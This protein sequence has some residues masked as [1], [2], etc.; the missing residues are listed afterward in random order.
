MKASSCQIRDLQK[1]TFFS[2]ENHPISIQD[3]KGLHV[4][5]DNILSVFFTFIS[6]EQS[7]LFNNKHMANFYLKIFP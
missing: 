2:S 7:V 6:C 3:S 1:G 4:N 5:F